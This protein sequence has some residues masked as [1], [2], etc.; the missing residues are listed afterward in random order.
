MGIN[1]SYIATY[2][3]SVCRMASGDLKKI[4]TSEILKKLKEADGDSTEFFYLYVSTAGKECK[5][6]TRRQLHI[7]RQQKLNFPPSHTED[8]DSD[9]TE[10]E[11]DEQMG[12][13]EVGTTT[14]NI[15][16]QTQSLDGENAVAED[17]PSPPLA[18]DKARQ[19]A[20]SK[21]HNIILPKV[22][23]EGK[24][25][26]VYD[27][28][29]TLTYR[30]LYFN[31]IPK[32][33]NEDDNAYIQRVGKIRT[34]LAEEASKVKKEYDVNF[35]INSLLSKPFVY[36]EPT[37]VEQSMREGSTQQPPKQK[38]LLIDNYFVRK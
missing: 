36:D 15:T 25:M 13:D 34:T 11:D 23:S 8:E 38:Q 21:V 35:K 31:I 6:Q 1:S 37:L 2:S 14:E 32:H 12:V 20:M 9:D 22:L 5:K 28:D 33:Q 16:Q 30:A 27:K 29:K 19:E 17:N 18:K 4:S 24:W 7:P 26:K 10:S 3:S